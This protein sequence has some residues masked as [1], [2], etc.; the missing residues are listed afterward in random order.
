M[1]FNLECLKLDLK[2]NDKENELFN[3]YFDELIEVNKVM[4]LTSITEKNEV[5]NKHFLDSL[6]LTKA[7]EKKDFML[8]DVGSGA[9]FPAI[10]NAIINKDA[11]I[12]II[13]SLGKRINFINNLTKKLCLSNVNA[14][15][16][17]AEDAKEFRE[18]FD[19]V[20]ARAVSK[21]N[22]LLELCM[23]LVR[24]GGSFIAM[25]SQNIEIE[26]DEAKNAINALGAKLDKI[27]EYELPDG[28][29]K[30]SLIIIKK[31]KN[32]NLKYP[33]KFSQIKDKPL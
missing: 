22:I 14:Y 32:T 9:G 5:F 16:L 3:I 25:K 27:I 28:A 17:R 21:L 30:R 7:L 24:V 18:K 6:Y 19:Y 26:L 33:R 4:N 10:P 15:H 8:C 20:T 2:L 11:K 23:P 12:V 29:G 1:D 31:I 13:D